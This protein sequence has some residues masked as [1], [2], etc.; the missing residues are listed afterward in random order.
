MNGARFQKRYKSR[1]EAFVILSFKTPC[2]CKNGY[3]W[4]SEAKE[5]GEESG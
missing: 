2:N 1:S 3:E 5:C 4:W